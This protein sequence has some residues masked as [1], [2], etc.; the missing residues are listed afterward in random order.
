MIT[1]TL[2]LLAAALIVTACG[3]TPDLP[4]APV[5]AVH[6]GTAGPRTY[7]PAVT[8]PLANSTAPGTHHARAPHDRVPSGTPGAH[9]GRQLL[10]GLVVDAPL[11]GTAYRRDA[12]GPAWFDYDAN[13]CGTRDDVLLMWLHNTKTG[14]GCDVTDGQ[15][16]DP[17]TGGLI[18]EPG[19]ID[20]DHVVSLGDA[21]R[22]GAMNWDTDK[23]TRFANDVRHLVPTSAAQNRSKGDK[24]ADR[25][26]PAD[27][28]YHCDY[29]LITIGTKR[30]YQLTI[31]PAERD[32]LTAAL[33]RC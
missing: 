1:R 8:A 15:L 20:I 33:D 29:A 6:T 12:Y 22:S 11:Q 3:Y 2:G 21:W 18:P 24:P 4:G 23:R 14:K 10:A 31:T 7:D 9:M 27:P 13:G 28:V 19:R 30:A 26:M 25:W 17:Y 32:A 5:P 16:V